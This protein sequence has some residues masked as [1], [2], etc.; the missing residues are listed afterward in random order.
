LKTAVT[1]TAQQEENY[2]KTSGSRSAHKASWLCRKV[3]Y[4]ELCHVLPAPMPVDVAAFVAAW[5]AEL[6]YPIV[7]MIHGGSILACPATP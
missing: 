3:A 4:G 7:R 2:A 6:V 1:V 5:P